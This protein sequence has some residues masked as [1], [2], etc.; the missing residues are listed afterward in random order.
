MKITYRILF[1]FL[2]IFQFLSCVKFK[3]ENVI[4]KIA[5]KKRTEKSE[6]ALTNSKIDNFSFPVDSTLKVR[7]LE[8]ETFHNDEVDPNLG[9]KIWF[10]LFKSK[11]NYTLAETKVTIKHAYDAIIDESEDEQTG[12]NVSVATKDTCVVLI[13]KLPYLNNRDI[14]SIILPKSIYPGD[15]FKFSFEGIEYVLSATGDKK[16]SDWIEVSNYKLYLTSKV[17]GKEIKDLLVAQKS[18]DDQMIKIIFAGD[19]DGDCKLDLIIDTSY[20]YNLS[21]PTLYFSKTAEKGKIIKPMGVFSYV[22]C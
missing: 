1:L 5:I 20:H 3:E 12:W 18:F 9:K 8:L 19:I 10:G 17:N 4:K 15:N 21:R 6:I 13:E 16:G 11:D 22:G 7:I 14:S 2:V